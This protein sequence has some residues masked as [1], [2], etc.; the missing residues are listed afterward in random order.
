MVV[1]KVQTEAHMRT[2][3][4]EC[5]K[6]YEVITEDKKYLK[7]E[8]GKTYQTSTII[9][10]TVFVFSDFWMPVSIECFK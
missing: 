9:D 7:L 1:T 4:R 2:Y 10:D 8:K 3:K 5:T 6:E